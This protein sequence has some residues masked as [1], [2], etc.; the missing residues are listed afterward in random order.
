MGITLQDI[1]VMLGVPVNGLLVVGKTNLTWK[2]VCTEL[3]GYTPPP[4]VPYPNENKFVLAG[5]R[6]QINWLDGQFRDPL[7][8][9]ACDVVV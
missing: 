6:I 7:A 3:L 9:D 5:A 2:D 1:E 8:M 4:S